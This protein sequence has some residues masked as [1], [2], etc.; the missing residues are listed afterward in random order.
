MK[1]LKIYKL[2]EYNY[3]NIR[4]NTKTIMGSIFERQGAIGTV[5]GREIHLL[6]G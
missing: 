6:S 1:M 2:E 3:L 4:N 5:K